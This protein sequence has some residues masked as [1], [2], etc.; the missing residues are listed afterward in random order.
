M[1]L[2]DPHRCHCGTRSQVI[3]TRR[4]RGYRS[5]RHK[6]PTCGKRWSTYETTIHPK[7]LKPAAYQI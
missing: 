2:R 5:R 1:T 4:Y 3:S 6:C 7:R